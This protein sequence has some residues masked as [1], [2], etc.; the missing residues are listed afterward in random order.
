MRRLQSKVLNEAHVHKVYIVY[1]GVIIKNTLQERKT[2]VLKHETY[3]CYLS[4]ICL[5]H[6][7]DLSTNTKHKFMLNAPTANERSWIQAVV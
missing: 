5:L 1:K 2:Q 3:V 7:K 4:I 6:G